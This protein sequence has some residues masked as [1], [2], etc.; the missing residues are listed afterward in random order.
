MDRHAN[1][2]HP[3]VSRSGK[4][5]GRVVLRRVVDDD[6]LPVVAFLAADALDRLGEE[7]A[8]VAG[9]DDHGDARLGHGCRS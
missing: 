7:S 5:L 3:R 4:P 6:Q 1:A 9:R 2:P 8:P